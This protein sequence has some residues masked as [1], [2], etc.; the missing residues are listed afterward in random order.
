MDLN[1]TTPVDLDGFRSAMRAAGVE[2]VVDLTIEVYLEDAPGLF[3]DASEAAGSGDLDRVRAHAHS[4]KS[5]SANIWATQLPTLFAALEQAA[6]QLDAA[7]VDET[8]VRLRPEFAR[9][10][11]YLQ[12][13]PTG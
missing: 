8:M 1:G 6:E 10:V 12:G 3:E 11:E 2:E 13:L 4:L 5:S 9:V 7:R